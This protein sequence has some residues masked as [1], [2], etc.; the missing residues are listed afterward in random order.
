[1]LESHLNPATSYEYILHIIVASGQLSDMSC[2]LKMFKT[3]Q[4]NVLI[5]QFNQTI[6]AMLTK[7]VSNKKESWEDYIETCI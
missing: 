6:Q 7:F 3:P 1:M 4:A 5:E 2:S